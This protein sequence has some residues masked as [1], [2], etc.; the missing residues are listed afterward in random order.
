MS[1]QGHQQSVEE[2]HQDVF[3]NLSLMLNEIGSIQ[4]SRESEPFVT[5]MYRE[6][7]LD[8]FIRG[9]QL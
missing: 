6:K 9:L 5:K 3:K 8:T 7:A 2:F 4:M 1:I